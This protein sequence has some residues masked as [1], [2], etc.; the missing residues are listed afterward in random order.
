MRRAIVALVAVA[1]MAV[2]VAPARASQVP[3]A[4]E[5]DARASVFVAQLDVQ[6]AFDPAFADARASTS[7]VGN[8]SLAS[9]VWPSFLVDAFFFLYGF[10]SVE[11]VGLGIAEARWPQGPSRA[12]ATQSNL[13]FANGGDPS[14]FPG[15]IGRS[16][17]T[18]DAD[19]GRAR[20]HTTELAAPMLDVADAASV[21]DA[22]AVATASSRQTL[23]RVAAG[24][25]VIG[26]LDAVADASVALLDA[27][28][29]RATITLTDV[30]VA[31]TPVRIDGDG[32]RAAT[33]DAQE[34]ANAALQAAGVEVRLVPGSERI[35]PGSASAS[36]G[37][38]LITFAQRRDDPTGAERDVRVGYLLGAASASARSTAIVG[39]PAPPGGPGHV[40]IP[41][42]TTVVPVGGDLDPAPPAG[43]GT[44]A[45]VVTESSAVPPIGARGAYAAVMLVAVALF[46][47]RPLVRAASRP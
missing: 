40:E 41:G 47:I 31:G 2:A 5:T 4:V 16:V 42:T 27:P 20:A 19:A 37:G 12:D 6:P 10:Q 8:A 39:P 14:M 34:A 15:A 11:R 46:G 3:A 30:T 13:L 24:P 9:V 33:A 23:R 26:H 25:L 17:A 1:F 38:V 36:T 32:V 18:A 28:R 35:E 21:A 7:T 22:S 44:R 45:L 29:A 43:R